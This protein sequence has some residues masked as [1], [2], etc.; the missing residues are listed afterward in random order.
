MWAAAVAADPS[1]VFDGLYPNDSGTAW[2]GQHIADAIA[3]DCVG[4]VP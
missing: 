2:L 4:V 3:N 1:L